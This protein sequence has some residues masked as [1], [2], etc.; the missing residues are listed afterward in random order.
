[1]P[2]INRGHASAY[3]TPCLRHRSGHPLE[4]PCAFVTQS[5]EALQVPTPRRAGGCSSCCLGLPRH[6]RGGPCLPSHSAWH[7]RG[8]CFR[9]GGPVNRFQTCTQSTAASGFSL[10]PP[11]LGTDWEHFSTPILFD[12]VHGRVHVNRGT[13]CKVHRGPVCPGNPDHGGRARPVLGVQPQGPPG[14][15]VRCGNLPPV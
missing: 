6:S 5:P 4:T 1:M 7:Q 14:D 3:E 2:T 11:S 12:L 8:P 15:C 13:R 9:G 10:V